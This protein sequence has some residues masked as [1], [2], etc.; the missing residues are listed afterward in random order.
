MPWKVSDVD[1]HKKGLSAKQKSQWVRV[2]NAALKKCMD[3]GGSDEECAPK[4]IRQANGVVGN[5]FSDHEETFE[6]H[7]LSINKYEVRYET[8]NGREHVVI[9]VVLFVEGVHNG[10]HG[11]ILHL[12]EELERFPEAWNGRP[13]PLCHPEENGEYISCNSPKVIEDSNCGWLFN[14]HFDGKLRSEAWL[15]IDKVKQ[16]EPDILFMIEKGAKIEGSTG[17]YTDNEIVSGVWNGEEYIGIARNYRPDHFAILLDSVGACSVA[18]GCGFGA[19]EGKGGEGLNP[20]SV[21]IIRGLNKKGYSVLQMNAGYGEVM[22]R[23]QNKLNAMDN[24][25]KIHFLVDVFE[26]NTFIYEVRGPNTSGYYKQ[27]YEMGDN[28]EITL[29]GEPKAV[30]RKVEFV[31]ANTQETNSEGG[32][33]MPKDKKC[34]GCE[35]VVAAL[36]AHKATKWEE[37]DETKLM[38]LGRELGKDFLEEL[39]PVEEEE[40]EEE[41]QENKED[42][43]ETEEKKP[44][45]NEKD[46]LAA[47]EGKIADKDTFLSLLSSDMRDYVE[48]GLT[49]HQEKRQALIAHITE[50]S[51][52]FTKDDLSKKSTK[53]LEALAELAG[54]KRDYSGQGAG[55]DNISAHEGVEPLGTGRFEDD[56]E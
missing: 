18:D 12:D 42:T 16:L 14:T 27:K 54:K 15:D 24:G 31:S 51:S 35:E 25:E 19:N 49:L 32:D 30:T 17:V 52:I 9:P 45:T 33:S 23:I 13:V 55:D 34:D 43:T 2:A 7:A 56:E 46:V 22:E 6:T 47:M 41:V 3:E 37:K 36:I 8:Y 20:I 29:K 21:E 48:A 28:E 40:S 5:E 26:D 4:A 53:E 38:D 50:R 10:S 1:E 39:L 11:P 44:E